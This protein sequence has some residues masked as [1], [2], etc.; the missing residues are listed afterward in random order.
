MRSGPCNPACP[1]IRSLNRSA[2]FACLT[3]GLLAV[4]AIDAQE[5]ARVSVTAESVKDELVAFDGRR[6]DAERTMLKIV[7]RAPGA[8]NT[9]QVDVGYLRLPAREPTQRSPIVFLMGG[10]GVPATLI[11]RIPPYWSLFNRLRAVADVILLDQRGTGISRPS[12]DCPAGAP[13]RPDFLASNAN[14]REALR[15]TYAPCAAMWRRRGFPPELFTVR[16]VAADVEALRLQLGVPR[17]SLLGFSYGTRLALEY[18]RLFPDHVDQVALQGTLGFDDVARL[19]A[20]LDAVLARVSALPGRDQVAST[21]TPNLQA[22]MVDLIRQ[23]EKEPL[24]VTTTGASG[25]AVRLTIG[26]EGLRAIV[27]GRIADPGLP[28]LVASLRGGD[29]R[30]LASGAAGIYRDLAAGGGSLFGRAVYCSAP[31]SEPRERSART[32]A[33]GS[34]IGEVFDNIPATPAFCRDI[35]IAPGR[36]AEQPLHGLYRPA[37]IITGTL[38]DR[39][40]PPNAERARRYFTKPNVVVVEHGGHELLPDDAVS[41][42]VIEFFATARV[43]REQL[44]V[45][46]PR[47]LTVDEALKPVVRR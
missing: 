8:N 26:A 35:G 14:L 32:L 45:P 34:I 9:V 17:V 37:L 46:P 36:L 29:T 12:I 43:S 22:A 27:A 47:F 19:P 3:A 20:E 6:Q 28:A 31:A 4:P 15:A 23:V 16:E 11:G 24:Q 10:P 39:T 33:A 5:I 13:P 2:A 30:L 38:D 25:E 44:A 18:V 40:P 42:L 21:L 1:R 7:Q 41:E